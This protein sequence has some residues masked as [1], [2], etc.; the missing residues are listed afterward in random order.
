MSAQAG[1]FYFDGRPV[2]PEIVAR[3]VDAIDPYGPDD[4]GEVVQPGLAMVFRAW[5]VTPEDPAARQPLISTR[6][7]VM[8]WDGRLDNRE[9]LLAQLWHERKRNGDVCDA[10]LA[11]KAYEKWGC[12]G[13][14][15]LIGDWSLVV[16]D[17]ESQAVVMASDYMG[18]R[19]LHYYRQANAVWWASTLDGLVRVLGLYDALEPR[20][21][22]GF[23]AS[24]R[25]AG[26]T[27]Y[28]GLLSVPTG[29]SL[30]VTRSGVVHTRRFW[31]LDAPEIRYRDP[32]DYEAH[33][34]S[35]FFAAVRARLRS[36]APVWSQLSGGLD[37]SAVV[38][39]ADVLIDQRLAV[40]P[41]LRTVAYVT[42][43]SP[44]TDERRFVAC[45]DEQCR[46]TTH[47]VQLDDAVE[48]VDPD[49]HW[50]SPMQLPW[51]SRETFSLM[52]RSG[53]RLLL[54]GIG[55][56]TLMG[57]FADY[58]HDVAQRLARGQLWS[59][60]G[61]ARRRGLAGQNSVW[62]VLYTASRE[63]APLPS[64]AQRM[65]QATLGGHGP[66]EASD[67]RS[68][69]D[70]LHVKRGY[71]AWWVDEWERQCVRA[72]SF[73][74][75][76]K[77][78]LAVQVIMMAER[79]HGQ[80][81][82]DEPLTLTSHPFLDRALVELMVG[83]PIEIIAPPGQPRGLM[84]RA[85]RPFMP[86][87]IVSRISKAYA[88]P[89][90]V[91]GARELLRQWLAAPDKLEILQLDFLDSPRLVHYLKTLSENGQQPELFVLLVKMERWLE[92]RKQRSGA[93]PLAAI[94]I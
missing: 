8:T 85:F 26:I 87:R 44:A 61:Q 68:V 92:A 93:S 21:L 50:I 82:A 12:E 63:L 29:E 28:A 20:Y 13:F 14:G 49:K 42:D 23:L 91:T 27:P 4:G 88:V 79:R 90:S 35:A 38:C 84:R 17:A 80:S 34:R 40:A 22:V 72:L 55:G 70:L 9:D 74:D 18:V 59:A 51:S 10:A 3:L 60:L 64:L 58:V 69:A 57:N 66:L 77:R 15:R 62:H 78:P 47:L 37:S 11:M 31:T 32:A 45:V 19:P 48:H 52:R 39:A 67:A 81:P 33:L 56:D 83:I 24:A 36:T 41:E 25:P 43:G 1:V 30:S 54:T 16:W 6:G 71:A 75:I 46:R 5:H 89:P 73:A 86:A 65:L 76:S 94:A 53:G 2:S 7:H